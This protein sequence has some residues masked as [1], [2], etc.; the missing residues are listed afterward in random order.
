MWRA[1]GGSS[2]PAG[3]SGR[4]CPGQAAQLKV[5]LLHA[6]SCEKSQ[7]L[8]GLW[9]C[10]CLSGRRT[11]PVSAG[12][13]GPSSPSDPENIHHQGLTLSGDR[14]VGGTGMSLPGGTLRASKH[15][16]GGGLGGEAEALCVGSQGSGC[17]QKK[18]SN[19]GPE[20]QEPGVG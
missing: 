2:L 16:G 10:L 4:S 17:S 5:H 15:S 11:T 19:L 9:A 14:C 20:G 6:L 1:G 18:E 13:L 3:R 8:R 12:D 7:D